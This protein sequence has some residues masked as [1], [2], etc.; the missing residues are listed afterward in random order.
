MIPKYKLILIHIHEYVKILHGYDIQIIKTRGFP[1]EIQFFS[2]PFRNLVG[3]LW[4]F[5]KGRFRTTWDSLG[6]NLKTR[7]YKSG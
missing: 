1:K 4:I 5:K 2:F 6:E 3:K 7:G